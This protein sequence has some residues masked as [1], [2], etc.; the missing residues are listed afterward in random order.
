M[1]TDSV[2]YPTTQL[3]QHYII[4]YVFNNTNID[5]EMF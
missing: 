4:S 2:R 3:I 1:Q 5:L